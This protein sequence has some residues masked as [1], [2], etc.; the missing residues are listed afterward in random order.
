MLL[1]SPSFD[2]DSFLFTS[3]HLYLSYPSEGKISLSEP[4]QVSLILH[5]TFNASI[6]ASHLPKSQA[7]ESEPEDEDQDQDP[8]GSTS[9]KKR[10][11]KKKDEEWVF[12]YQD[13]PPSSDVDNNYSKKNKDGMEIDSNQNSDLTGGGEE[14]GWANGDQD[15]SQQRSLGYWRSQ[16]DG[17]KLGGDDGK[18]TFTIIR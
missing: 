14:E 16:K 17:R 10:K 3:S 1:I 7:E 4:S 12:I 15:L 13:F 6:S 2:S 11:S 8:E 18:V 9:S 5:N